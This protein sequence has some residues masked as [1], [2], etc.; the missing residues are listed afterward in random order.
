MTK[1]VHPAEMSACSVISRNHSGIATGGKRNPAYWRRLQRCT[2][3]QANRKAFYYYSILLVEMILYCFIVQT[4][5]QVSRSKCKALTFLPACIWGFEWAVHQ[6]QPEWASY[7][8]RQPRS[9][10]QAVKRGSETSNGSWL[11]PC[12][13][14]TCQTPNFKTTTKRSH[15]THQ[16]P[17]HQ[18]TWVHQW[19]LVRFLESCQKQP[20]HMSPKI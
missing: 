14:R 12:S 18:K 15:S 10:S 1:I 9:V 16:P 19:L 17:N 11:L 8:Q 7:S 20:F 6:L 2:K 3:M 4:G 5:N 13:P